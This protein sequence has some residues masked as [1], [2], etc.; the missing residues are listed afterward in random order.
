MFFS[1]SR[2]S[3]PPHQPYLDLMKII[4]IMVVY[5]CHNCPTFL[6]LE[7]VDT[8][9]R[10]NLSLLLIKECH[11]FHQVFPTWWTLEGLLNIL[12]PNELSGNDHK[13]R[14]STGTFNRQMFIN[15]QHGPQFIVLANHSKV[16]DTTDVIV[17]Q[18]LVP[19]MVRDPHINSLW[20]RRWGAMANQVP[21]QCPTS[22]C[23]GVRCV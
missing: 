16:H 12:N 19:A 11:Y 22:L 5:L 15:K 4:H 7:L 8:I 21:G 1:I 18:K 17:T 13:S 2:S 9:K 10:L 3:T 23:F 14:F 6:G 20:P